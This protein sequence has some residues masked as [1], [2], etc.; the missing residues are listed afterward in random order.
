MKTPYDWMLWVKGKQVN[1]SFYAYNFLVCP[2]LFVLKILHIFVVCGCRL[3]S[4]TSVLDRVIERLE[5]IIKDSMAH[6][7]SSVWI[8]LPGVESA[9]KVYLSLKHWRS[10]FL[11]RESLL[12]PTLDLLSLDEL[13]DGIDFFDVR[14]WIKFGLTVEE[15]EA[16]IS[17]RWGK[18]DTL[19]ELIHDLLTSQYTVTSD[20]RA[21]RVFRD[22]IVLKDG[23]DFVIEMCKKLIHSKLIIVLLSSY[24]IERLTT[25]KFDPTKVD[26]TL[27]EWILAIVCYDIVEALR[28][29]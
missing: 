15:F 14:T 22:K 2:L 9:D 5:S 27:V 12:T 25:N 16:F 1:L 23:E 11:K 21:V 18:D 20:N 24:A 6:L 29:K 3:C 10:C 7:R 8:Q 26:N 13:K 28:V 19:S 4:P 17:Y